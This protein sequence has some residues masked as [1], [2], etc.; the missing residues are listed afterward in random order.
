MQTLSFSVVNRNPLNFSKSVV[1]K[2]NRSRYINTPRLRGV[3]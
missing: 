3:W 2:Q 1:K